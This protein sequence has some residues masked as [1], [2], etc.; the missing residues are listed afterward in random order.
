MAEENKN[1]IWQY[2]RQLSE[3]EIDKIKSIDH[4]YVPLPN[5]I[6]TD[7]FGNIYEIPKTGRTPL[8]SLDNDY[9]K[10]SYNWETKHLEIYVE[11][12]DSD[13]F[14]LL[15]EYSLTPENFLDNPEYWYKVLEVDYADYIE[16]VIE[17]EF[18]DAG[19]EVAEAVNNDSQYKYQVT[20]YVKFHIIKGDY[21]NTDNYVKDYN[22]QIESIRGSRPEISLYGQNFT[23]TAEYNNYL[24]QLVTII[25]SDIPLDLN[26]ILEL[27]EDE[28]KPVLNIANANYTVR[29]TDI[30]N[31]KEI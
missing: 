29:V 3:A 5:G 15:D 25:N 30:E 9:M 6:V 19:K 4:P 23:Y 26:D 21:E 7:G 2:L 8:V 12:E 13:K 22:N 14:S 16:S 11:D 28:I 18:V 20:S 17:N 10:F 1:S 31:I 27:F 24:G